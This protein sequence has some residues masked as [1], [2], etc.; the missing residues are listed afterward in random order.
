MLRQYLGTLI[1][2]ALAVLVS[3]PAHC[4]FMLAAIFPFVLV[5]FAFSGYVM[6]KAPARR[7][8]QGIKMLAWCAVFAGVAGLHVHYY[9]AAR[10]AG[11]AAVAAL[12]RYRQAHGGSFPER[13]ADAGTSVGDN[14]AP[15]HV[16][17]RLE[18]GKP[19]LVYSG[20]FSVFE[21]YTY[22]FEQ[23]RWRYQV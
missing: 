23:G 3:A 19:L 10:Q 18:Q 12:A 7:R 17:Y 14:D 2:G 21:T 22:D 9:L 4:G 20:N 5:W 8:P 13:L 1:A 11:D 6:V 16:L 15:W